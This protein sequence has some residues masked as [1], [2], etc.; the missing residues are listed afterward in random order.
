MSKFSGSRLF[1]SLFRHT[2]LWS[3]AIAAGY[4]LFDLLTFFSGTG[5]L[6]YTDTDPYTRALRITD[7]LQDFQWAE[8]IFPYSNYP[9]GDIL[10]FTRIND[11]IWVFLCLPFFPWLPLKEAVFY[12]GMLFNPLFLALSVITVC[13]GVKPYLHGKD[14]LKIFAFAYILGWIFLTKSVGIFDFNRPDHHSL[15]F[16]LF[17]LNISLLLRWLKSPRPQYLFCAGIAAAAGIWTS[18]AVEGL[19]MVFVILSCLCNFWFYGGKTLN[20]AE[21]YAGGLF[22]GTLAAFLINPPYGGLFVFNTG[23]L[24]LVHVVL[25]ALIFTAFLLLN[26]LRLNGRPAKMAAFCGAALFSAAVMYAIFGNVLFTPVYDENVKEYF[27]P[28]IDEM[29][30]WRII[31]ITT[32]LL[33]FAVCLW[34]LRVRDC[35]IFQCLTIVFLPYMPLSILITRFFYYSLAVFVYLNFFFLQ[36]IFTKAES[37]KKYTAALFGYLVGCVFFFAS[38]HAA[39]AQKISY[40]EI[41][42]CVLTD[43]FSAPQLM[44]EKDVYT[45]GTPYHTNGEAIG[46]TFHLFFDTDEKDIVGLLKKHRIKYLYMAK[47]AGLPKENNAGKNNSASPSLRSIIYGAPNPYP[48]L[49]KISAPDD[50]YCLYEV[51]LPQD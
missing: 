34:L 2:I 45:V 43:I 7:W 23:R 1:S 40:P 13:G 15:M 39:K 5:S 8:K 35:L 3:F 17:C 20:G 32:V 28:Y 49:K 18:S 30:G 19:I 33:G 37:S 6:F 21:S 27:L 9:F 22:G 51:L 47:N 12:G 42:G 48:W 25:T 46:D 44:F 50:E 14:K 36:E 26:K 41:S 29:R 38:F 24:S 10:H 31:D 16:F 4:T 11:I